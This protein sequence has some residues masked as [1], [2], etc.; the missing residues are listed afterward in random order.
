MAFYV[1]VWGQSWAALKSS[2]EARRLTAVCRDSD[3]CMLQLL[4][5][6]ARLAVRVVHLVRT[7]QLLFAADRKLLPRMLLLHGTADNS[8]PCEIAVEFSTLLKASRPSLT[9]TIPV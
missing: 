5:T 3:T 7:S 9:G 2:A 1:P 6:P 4:S 8:V